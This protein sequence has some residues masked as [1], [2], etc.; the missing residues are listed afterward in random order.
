M[1]FDELI[2]RAQSVYGFRQLS[3]E[4]TAGSVAAALET[5]EG[6]VYVGGVHRHGVLAWLLR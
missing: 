6:H 4:A 1:T 3:P 2:A 5:D